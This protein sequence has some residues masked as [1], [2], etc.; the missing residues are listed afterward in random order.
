[1]NQSKSTADD[2]AVFEKGIDLMGMGIGG[3][4]KVFGNFS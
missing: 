4:I 2:T 1:L 3:D